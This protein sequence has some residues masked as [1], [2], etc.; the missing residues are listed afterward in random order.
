MTAEEG[1]RFGRYELLKRHAVG[2]M[3]EL[4]RAILRGPSGFSKVVAIKKIRPDLAKDSRFRK[5]FLH[6]GRIM[7]A[8]NHRNLVQVFELGEVDNELYLSLEFVEGC[9]LSEVIKYCKKN[10]QRFDPYQAAWIAREICSGLDYLHNIKDDGGRNLKIVHRDVN[11]GN[12]LLS[13]HGDVKLGDFGIARSIVGE[14][15]TQQGQVKG[16]VKYLSP[17]QA[18]GDTVDP[19]TDL[20]AVGLVLYEMLTGRHYIL[21]NGF[22]ELIDYA[23][24]PSWSPI[25]PINPEVPAELEQLTRRA[26]RVKPEE[27]FHSA[28]IFSDLLSKIIDS[29][30]SPVSSR[31]L[32]SLVS[33]VS[34]RVD[35]V[36][37]LTQDNIQTLPTSPDSFAQTADKKQSTTAGTRIFS[38]SLGIP[39][40]TVTISP[41]LAEDDAEISRT[42]KRRLISLVSGTIVILQLILLAVVWTTNDT[43]EEKIDDVKVKKVTDSD[44]PRKPALAAGSRVS[45]T[46]RQEIEEIVVEA[47][48]LSLSTPSRPQKPKRIQKRSKKRTPI[49]L[50][51]ELAQRKSR[52]NSRGVLVGDSRQIDRLLARFQTEKKSQFDKAEKTLH[53]LDRAIEE[54]VIDRRFVEQKMKRL[55]RLLLKSR[56]KAKY[57][58]AIQEILNYVINNHFK[59]A[60]NAINKLIKRFQ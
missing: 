16:K 45:E 32:T 42:K 6:E 60:N 27:R 30:P 25:K 51:K 44:L 14:A 29:A 37:E 21:G 10:K 33:V 31:S 48:D 11:P 17:E 26:L 8:M 47:V 15:K 56:Q 50:E 54:L 5:M 18:R 4:Y 40:N 35:S 34:A 24:N 46:G 13:G 1:D 2:G 52:L 22:L 59:K 53:A 36:N 43:P 12:I 28:R 39:T 3:A 57:T 55:N 7:A 19:R 23:A 38:S 9:N 20:F 58:Q 49:R 41:H